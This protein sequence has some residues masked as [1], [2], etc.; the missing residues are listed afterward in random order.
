MVKKRETKKNLNFLCLI[1]MTSD[2][3]L[4]KKKTNF[5]NEMFHHCYEF[6][7][8]MSFQSYNSYLFKTRAW[9]LMSK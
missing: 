6:N 5:P 2:Y 8:F 3:R 1:S 7:N 4:K 9:F